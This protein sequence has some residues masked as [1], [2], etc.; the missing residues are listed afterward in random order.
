MILTKADLKEYLE[1]DRIA[2]VG[3]DGRKRPAFYQLSWRYT[4]TLRKLEYYNNKYKGGNK[5]YMPA[6]FLYKFKHHQISVKSG[7]QINV[8]I[9]DKGLSIPHFGLIVVNNNSKI[10]KN[11]RIHNGVYI[12]PNRGSKKCPVIG[13]NVYI[14]PGAKIFGDIHIADNVLIGANAVVTKSIDTPNCTVAGVPARIIKV[15]EEGI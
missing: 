10:G 6:Y 2:Q 9:A 1:A 13:D 7:I 5:L 14:G 12:T 3:E 15:N 4:R 11:C 8:N